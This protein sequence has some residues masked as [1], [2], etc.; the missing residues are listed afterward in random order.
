[1]MACA[2]FTEH[3]DFT[4][5]GPLL[6]SPWLEQIAQQFGATIVELNYIFCDDAFLHKLNKQ[7]RNHDTFTDV[8]TFDYG[9]AKDRITGDCYISIPSVSQN[10]INYHVSLLQEC[11]RVILHGLLHLLGHRDDQPA[12]K[13]AMRA[14]EDQGLASPL[15]QKLWQGPD[16]SYPNPSSSEADL[17]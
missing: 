9:N 5:P 1:M 13:K 4:F 7:Y 2:F 14:A 15:L 16:L 3:I 11:C 6:L 12:A 10:A 8:L 17:S